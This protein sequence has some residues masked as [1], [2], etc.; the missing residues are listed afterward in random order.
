M[1]DRAFVAVLFSMLG[2]YHFGCVE[3]VH[4]SARCT[5]TA[6]GPSRSSLIRVVDESQPLPPLCISPKER[7]VQWELMQQ[8][9]GC[10]WEGETGWFTPS[11]DDAQ[12][13][14]SASSEPLA[15]V[16]Q[17]QFPRDE[18]EVGA[19]RG[20]GVIKP[21]DERTVPLSEA[22]VIERQREQGSSTFQFPGAGGRCS[23]RL[24]QVWAVAAV[25][26]FVVGTWS[27]VSA[28]SYFI[29]LPGLGRGGE[30]LP[31]RASLRRRR[32]PDAARGQ[33]SGGRV[34]R[35]QIS[36]GQISRGQISRG[37]RGGA[38]R[39]TSQ[40]Q[41]RRSCSEAGPSCEAIRGAGR[42]LRCE[43]RLG[44]KGGAYYLLS[45]AG[46][47]RRRCG[48]RSGRRSGCGCERGGRQRGVSHAHA[49]SVRKLHGDELPQGA[50]YP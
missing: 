3:A 29:A 47:R 4:V 46:R 41:S 45:R 22:T 50:A 9:F 21:G 7:R 42:L 12:E 8:N 39:T 2:S 28:W 30:L 31:R 25:V 5:Q 16:Y 43:D 18:P 33:I 38:A 11:H 35:G 20:W 23:L 10:R 32:V 37:R 34:S 49:T 44:S 19:W 36:R 15:A 14:V 17:L 27:M 24:G 13:L 40:C 26:V 48:C 1:T 6:H